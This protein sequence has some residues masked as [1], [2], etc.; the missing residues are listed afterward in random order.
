MY[1]VLLPCACIQMPVHYAC[2][3][4]QF[5][6]TNDV[7]FLKCAELAPLRLVVIRFGSTNDRPFEVV[8]SFLR[9]LSRLCTCASSDDS[10]CFIANRNKKIH[11]DRPSK[12]KIQISQTMTKGLYYRG[13]DVPQTAVF[14]L[15]IPLT[16]PV[17]FAK[18][19]TAISFA[20]TVIVIF[21]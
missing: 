16:A 14:F 21:P 6:R 2:R 3:V 4:S 18:S 13:S 5:K 7:I 20:K 10:H 8:W 15:L 1:W 12:F 17:F 11:L 9:A 19:A